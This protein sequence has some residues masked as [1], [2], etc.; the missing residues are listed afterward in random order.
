[1]DEVRSWRTVEARLCGHVSLGAGWEDASPIGDREFHPS[2]LA[3]AFPDLQQ[4]MRNL[5]M[6]G[7]RLT[8]AWICVDVR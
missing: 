6:C 2:R 4:L 8:Y 3:H 5:H 7:D 1:M